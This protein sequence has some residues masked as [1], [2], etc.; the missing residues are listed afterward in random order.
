ME[1]IC[2]F[3][4]PSKTSENIYPINFVYEKKLSRVEPKSPRAVY[5]IHLVTEGTAQIRCGEHL[6]TVE[7][8]DIFFIF[9]SVP[10][11]ILGDAGFKYM[12]ISFFGIR[13]N[14]E[15][16]RLGINSKNYVFRDF[17]EL[18]SLWT[19][20]IELNNEVID[21]VSEG[22]LLFTLSKIGSKYLAASRSDNIS[23]S[24]ANASLIKKYI[25]DNFRDTSLS[26]DKI[27]SEFSYSKKYISVLF[28]KHFKLGIVEYIN[29]LRMNYACKII[30]E[31]AL[32]VAQIA[33]RSG[34]KD[35]LYFS[36]VFKRRTG[37]SPKAYIDRNKQKA[38]QNSE[39]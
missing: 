37:F 16:E 39:R 24:A 36:K 5:S 3:T 10:Y 7:P 14:A 6:E 34:F 19:E 21:L 28:K 1:S 18:T 23:S 30:D 22:V 33:F 8:G 31:E 35:A 13:A 25:D 2:R 27:G 26:L 12:Y 32:S 15:L 20:S 11:A 38:Q 4:P 29:I 17:G 9:P